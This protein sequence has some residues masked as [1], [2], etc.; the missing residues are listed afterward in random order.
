[1]CKAKPAQHT[2]TKCQEHQSG[3]AELAPASPSLQMQI[4]FWKGQVASAVLGLEHIIT[5][6]VRIPSWGSVPCPMLPHSFG[7]GCVDGV[8][9]LQC[10]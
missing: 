2:P 10:L 6:H 3:R 9:E 4:S 8:G 5:A 1:M 7:Q